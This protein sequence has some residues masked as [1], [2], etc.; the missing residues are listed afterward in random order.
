M[1]IFGSPEPDQ[2]MQVSYVPTSARSTI[3]TVTHPLDYTVP[4]GQSFQGLGL[5]GLG[6]LGSFYQQ[7]QQVPAQLI[8]QQTKQE[9]RMRLLRYTVVDPDQTLAD[10]S[11]ET[12]ILKAGTIAVNGTDD[13]GFL[14]DLASQLG[15]L[16]ISHNV[17][18]ET[19]Q[20]EDKEG[21]TKTLKPIKL[22]NLD[23]VIEVLKAYPSA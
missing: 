19:I 16:L 20:Y 3:T 6:S 21:K 4:L 7:A 22:S 1:K 12:S 11:P 23:V 9:I 5:Q 2:A 8:T 14:M 13:R 10:K 17:A 18:R 15:D